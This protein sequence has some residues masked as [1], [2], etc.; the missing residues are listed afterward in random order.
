LYGKLGVVTAGVIGGAQANFVTS[1]LDPD[2]QKLAAFVNVG[3]GRDVWSRSDIT[4][5]YGQQLFKGKLDRNFTYLQASARFG[6]EF[7]LFGSSEFDFHKV[8]GTE[9]VSRFHMTNSF[10]T[11]TYSPAFRWLTVNAG[12]DAT[13]PVPLLESEK[14]FLDTLMDRSLHQGL[15]GSLSFQLPGRLVLTT[16]GT[17][18]MA[19]RTISHANSASVG[20]RASDVLGSGFGL[21]AQY[22]DAKSPYADG[23]DLVLDLD[24]WITDW[25][26]AAVRLD[27]YDYQL[28]TQSDRHRMT[29]LSINA[30]GRISSAW[31]AALSGDRIWEDAIIT[32]RLYIEIGVRF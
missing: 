31:Y 26:T 22:G 27:R 24:R 1:G 30:S 3:W 14:T 11:V 21:G 29:T 13:R 19:T 23:K 7:F 9:V 17:Y 32:H 25:L 5:A 2:H 16:T 10:V 15:R 8:V 12:Y 20:L 18:R 28:F 6:P 4:L